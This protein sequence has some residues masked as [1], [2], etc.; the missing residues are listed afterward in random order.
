M[1]REREVGGVVYW[2]GGGVGNV[3]SVVV[4]LVTR[5]SVVVD[6]EM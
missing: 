3:I 6:L 4:E 5:Y 1:E 2:C